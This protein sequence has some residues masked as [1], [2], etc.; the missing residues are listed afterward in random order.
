MGDEGLTLKGNET[1]WDMIVTITGYKCENGAHKYTL[2]DAKEVAVDG[3]DWF[4]QDEIS[5][6]SD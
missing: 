5:G 4:A 2:K 3:G 1:R 6:R